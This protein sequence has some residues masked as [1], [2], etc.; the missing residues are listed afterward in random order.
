[1][2]SLVSHPHHTHYAHDQFSM[3]VD[4]HAHHQ[5][6]HHHQPSSFP[7]PSSLSSSA[8][9][10]SSLSGFSA[11]LASTSA[12]SRSSMPAS[13]SAPKYTHV[14]DRRQHQ[15]QGSPSLQIQTAT[16]APHEQEPDEQTAHPSRAS[17]S[18]FAA[19]APHHHHDDQ[20]QHQP[21]QQQGQS[22]ADALTDGREGPYGGLS[23]PL[24]MQERDLL[25]HLDRLK[26]FLATA[27][28]RWNAPSPPPPSTLPSDFPGSLP[29]PAGHPHS[30]HPALN[31]FLLP[32]QEYV[33]CVLWG[34]LYH[35]TGTD[36]VR[37]LVFRF[38]AFGRPVRNMKKFEEGVFSDLRNLKPGVD[39]C[40]EEPKSPFLD[41]LFKYQCI[42]TQK[43]QKVF[44][45]FSVPH[46]R[47]FLDA[48]ERDLKR[49]KMGLEPTTVVVGEPALSFTYDPKRSL[50]EQF[51]KAHGAREG[52]GEL[53]VAV[54]RAAA[55]EAADEA[56]ERDEDGREK[57][58]ASAS[59]GE[60]SASD[61]DDAMG[62]D[63]GS[64]AKSGSS[65]GKGKKGPKKPTALS[66]PHSPFF[67]MFSLFEGSPTYKQRRKKVPKGRKSPPTSMSALSAS[68]PSSSSSSALAEYAASSPP[69]THFGDEFHQ[70][71]GYGAVAGYA[72]PQLDRFGRDTLRLSAHEMFGRGARGEFGANPDV[73]VSQK[74]RQ[75]RAMDEF[76]AAAAAVAAQGKLAYL[77]G[78]GVAPSSASAA[79]ASSS[80]SASAQDLMFAQSAM[81]F[82]APG[83]QQQHFGAGQQ[84]PH[85]QQQ[86]QQQ[87]HNHSQQ[88][89]TLEQR[90]TYPLVDFTPP[91][92]RTMTDPYALP[93]AVGQGLTTGWAPSMPAGVDLDLDMD[94]G[95]G[96]MGL[97]AGMG[98]SSTSSALGGALVDGPR[99]KAFVCPLFSCGRMFKRMEHLRRH[100]RTHT[101]ERPF[102]CEQ[103]KKRFSR[104]DNLAQHVRT[105]ERRAAAAAASAPSSVESVHGVGMGMGMAAA[106]G[107]G[108]G[109]AE[110]ELD[111][112]GEDLERELRYLTG[113]GVSGI[114]SVQMCEVEVRGQ[115]HEVQGDEEGLL[116]TTGPVSLTGA[117]LANSASSDGTSDQGVFYDSAGNVLRASPE[118][119]PYLSATQH[120]PE[121]QWA[122]IPPSHPHPH[123]SQHQQQQQQPPASAVGLHIAAR[124]DASYH[125][126]GAL[127][128]Y[129]TSISAPSHKLTF[130]HGALYPPELALSAGG[131]PSGS[132]SAGGPG[133]IRRHRSAT[134]SI[135]RYAESIRRPFSAALSDSANG[136]ANANGSGQGGSAGSSAA[137]SSAGNRSYHPY[138]VPGHHQPSS[139]RS[140]Q[141][142][143]MA[144]S[145]PLGYDAPRHPHPHGHSRSSSSGQLQ[146][147]M[148]QMLSLDQMD[149]ESMAQQYAAA[150]YRTDSPMQYGADAY[151]MSSAHQQQQQQQQ[152]SEFFSHLNQ[153]PHHSL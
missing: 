75:R 94:L 84:L 107:E 39:A 131:S 72:E 46:D 43:K 2:D 152:P 31:R 38:E 144:Y 9:S 128:D 34:G 18:S 82:V 24:T 146:E 78:P 87:Q 93:P 28:S 47:L 7:A 135:P 56:G 99:T 54:R 134:P 5:H 60:H 153:H 147:Q 90:H 77:S 66:G 67:P 132:G 44:Y 20:Q 117:A 59:E 86:Q 130:D 120:S 29:V 57:S 68:G 141:S 27:P 53:E 64:G 113:G 123:S 70:T 71:T 116:T 63:G 3:Q 62:E 33:S 23:R 19:A 37:A 126:A 110:D 127:G 52:E 11:G 48:L 108:E 142:S 139:S 14:L 16:P 88:R 1:M 69:F 129:V 21:Q 92:S 79:A 105:H 55:G 13:A 49:E 148:R 149:A 10:S 97:G 50:Y 145:V 98:S 121:S 89:P 35:I 8:S 65:G 100:L 32:N 91:P 150:M 96:S 61:A 151:G 125:T 51:S 111:L 26:F 74:E 41:L 102:Q 114:T 58:V 143:P 6:Q 119:S 136:N 40:L 80:S 95:M 122:T 22:I 140:A 83:H 106:A 124:L 42:R 73:V 81:E 30:A 109:G 104:S 101:L 103:C 15:Q 85:Q 45:W 25:A 12:S 138:A 133:P 112:D 36:I 76:A 4:A 118:T 137:G 17:S 115:V